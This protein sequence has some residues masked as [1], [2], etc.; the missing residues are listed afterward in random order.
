MAGRKCIV[1][2]LGRLVGVL[3]MSTLLAGCTTSA[4]GLEPSTADGGSEAALGS[5][6]VASIGAPPATIRPTACQAGDHELFLGADLVDPATGMVVRLVIDPLDGPALRVYD[7]DAPFDRTVLFFR[8]ECS[9]FDMTLGETG[10]IVNNIVERT[11]ELEV[12]CENE[13]GATIRGRARAASCD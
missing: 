8:E 3:S 10:T 5:F 6:D 4:T 2:R 7:S 1:R 12:D 13:L 11:L 9:Q